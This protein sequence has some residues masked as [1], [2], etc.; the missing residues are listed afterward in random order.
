M[1]RRSGRVH[2]VERKIQG[3]KYLG[4]GELDECGFRIADCG[5]EGLNKRSRI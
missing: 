5:I 2:G 3:A 4:I 1:F